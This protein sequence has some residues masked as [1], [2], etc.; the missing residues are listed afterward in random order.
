[1][2]IMIV[3]DDKPM[4][5]LLKTLLEMEKFTVSAPPIE[6]QNRLLEHISALQP[7]ILL[8]DVNLH[9][10]SGLDLLERIRSDQTM[11]QPRV[12]MTSGEDLRDSCLSMGADDFLLKP[13]MPVDL[14]ARLHQIGSQ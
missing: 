13:Y 8:M 11:N 9:V 3:E 1:M 12:I 5:S 6:D 2:H 7:D 10:F 4:R 14:I